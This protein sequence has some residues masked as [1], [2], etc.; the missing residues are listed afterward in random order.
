MFTTDTRVKELETLLSEAM[1]H[2]QQLMRDNQALAEEIERFK[3][4]NMKKEYFVQVRPLTE[5]I[6]TR[7]T[8][9]LIQNRLP[10]C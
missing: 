7:A 6:A 1:D 4:I 8:Y 3:Q 9:L 10:K 5:T 2:N